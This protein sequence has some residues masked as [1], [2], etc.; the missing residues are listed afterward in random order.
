MWFDHPDFSRLMNDFW[1][2][3]GST[4]EGWRYKLRRC[5]EKLKGWNL[6]SFG[7]VQR[8]IKY[9]KKELE[10]VRREDRRPEIVEKEQCI[11]EELDRW[12]A[13]EETLWMQRSRV[14]WME[15]G[16]KNTKFFHAKASQRKQRNWISQL[17]DP[18]GILHEDEEKI[19]SIVTDY[20]SNI[21]QSSISGNKEV[22][23]A[24][25]RDV[26]TCITDSSG[27]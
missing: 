17:K 1:E 15:Q 19:M 13:R 6:T 22:I 25:L 7:N 27:H 5:K 21:F 23:D 3:E 18:Q 2:E 11:I 4:D 16:D 8:K 24:E 10:D 9:L 12:M 26:A 14:L 20:F